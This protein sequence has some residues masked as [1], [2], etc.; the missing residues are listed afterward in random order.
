MAASLNRFTAG[1]LAR[2]V[3]ATLGRGR[4]SAAI[5]AD[6]EAQVRDRLAAGSLK[7]SRGK[8]VQV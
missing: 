2:A 7:I 3:G 8:L 6:L 1:T 4:P 5:R